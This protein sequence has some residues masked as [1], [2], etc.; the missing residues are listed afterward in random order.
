[1]PLHDGQ[2]TVTRC[3]ICDWTHTGEAGVGRALFA[4][5]RR[6][7]HAD[8]P[9][10]APQTSRTKAAAQP[11]PEVEK[12]EEEE[13]MDEPEQAQGRAHSTVTCKADGC[14][15][16]APQYGRYARLCADHRHTNGK[17]S[18]RTK[19]QVLHDL[20]AKQIQIEA[21]KGRLDQLTGEFSV[22]ADEFT[23]AT[24]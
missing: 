2:Q 15:N 6:N 22:L 7:A 19:L 20:T 4:E 5:H 16:E 8:K 14:T 9:T 12:Q 21:A 10:L 13:P 17:V 18:A 3:G 24:L 11:A 1:M 23:K